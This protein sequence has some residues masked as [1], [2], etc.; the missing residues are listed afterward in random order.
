[1]LRLGKPAARDG[2]GRRIG[3]PKG[4]VLEKLGHT[5]EAADEWRQSV[6]RDRDSPAVRDLKR[7]SA[8]R[9]TL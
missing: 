9:A 7:I 8:K 6:R 5:G 1:M 3:A 4:Q 2:K